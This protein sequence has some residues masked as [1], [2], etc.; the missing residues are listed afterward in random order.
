MPAGKT[1]DAGWEI[2]VSR[3]LPYELDDVWSLMTSSAGLRLWLGDGVR[4]PKNV[5]AEDATADGTTGELRGRE[6]RHR[7]RLTHRA[8]GARHETT[9][10]TTVEAKPTG[11]RLGFHQE[12]MGS[13]RER[14][15]QRA[16]WKSVMDDIENALGGARR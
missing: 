12:R 4:L 16:H 10:Q 2:G 7:L 11:T 6:E 5:G 8:P 15:R 1:K 14:E 9:I 13:A 3:T